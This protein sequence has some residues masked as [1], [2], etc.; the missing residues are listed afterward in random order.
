MTHIAMIGGIFLHAEDPTSLAQWYADHFELEFQDWGNCKG[1]AFSYRE[2]VNPDQKSALIFSIH[3]A[4]GKLA[5]DRGQVV[6][7]YRVHDLTKTL[8]KLTA[9]GVSILE[10]EDSDF[11]RFAWVNDPE[12]NRVELWQAPSNMDEMG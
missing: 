7:N 11:G 2:A 12:G 8:D 9:M 3:K 5:E 4:K 6:I 10:R 1:L